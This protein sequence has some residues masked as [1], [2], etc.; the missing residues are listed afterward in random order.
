LD[1]RLC[2]VSDRV[3]DDTTSTKEDTISQGGEDET[4]EEA[5]TGFGVRPEEMH[6]T[7]EWFHGKVGRDVSLIFLS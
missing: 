2:Y 5:P 7:E 6:V 4:V 1:D 3:D